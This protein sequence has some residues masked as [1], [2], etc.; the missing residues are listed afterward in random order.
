MVVRQLRGSIAWSEGAPGTRVEIRVPLQEALEMRP[1]FAQ[2][3]A[4]GLAEDGRLGL[5]RAA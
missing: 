2:S 4:L 5:E 1:V 3:A